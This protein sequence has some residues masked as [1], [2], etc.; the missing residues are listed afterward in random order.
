MKEE[1]NIKW[2]GHA[3]AL[4]EEF[5]KICDTPDQ[6]YETVMREQTYETMSLNTFG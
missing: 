1:L 3:I 4:Y 5:T 2:S 6:T